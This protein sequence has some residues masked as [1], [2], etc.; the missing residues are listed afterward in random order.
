[1]PVVIV[2]SDWEPAIRIKIA[3]R[4]LSGANP[5]DIFGQELRAG[6]IRK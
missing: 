6:Q 3:E 4:K 2:D 5:K 1:M